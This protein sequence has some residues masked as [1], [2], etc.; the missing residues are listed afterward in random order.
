MEDPMRLLMIIATT[1]LLV[2]PASAQSLK[3]RETTSSVKEATDRLV[4]A[5]EEKGLKVAARV[6][7]AAGAKAAGLDMPATEVVMFGNP[8]LG[9]PLMLANPHLAIDLP[10][11]I[12]IWEAAPGK[13]MIGY[14]A[15][16]ALKARFEIKDKD[17]LF[18]AM[19]DAL[20]GFAAAAAG[21]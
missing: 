13:T 14:T 4:K 7:H 9:T 15:P 18:K 5:V 2:V 3:V 11:K 8:K 19:G 20:E 10:L 6:D 21:P 16:D 1:L 17:A 12:V